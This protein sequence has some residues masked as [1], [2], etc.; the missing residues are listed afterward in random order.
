MYG[1]IA[2]HQGFGQSAHEV[3]EHAEDLAAQ[4]LATALGISFDPEATRSER[5]NHR[6][7]SGHV[8]ESRS[9]EMVSEVPDQGFWTTVVAA[10]VV[11]G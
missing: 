4:M 8:V 7:R 10:A 2:E 5:R 11:C 3:G 1:Y 6:R 9:Y